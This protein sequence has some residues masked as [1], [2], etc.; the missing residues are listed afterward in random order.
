MHAGQ[1]RAALSPCR[2]HLIDCTTQ[3]CFTATGEVWLLMTESLENLRAGTLAG[4]VRLTLSCGLTEFPSEIYALAE[5]LETLDLSGNKLSSL[6]DDLHRLK[7][8]RVLFCSDNLFTELPAVLGQF[9]RLSMIGFKANRISHVP[10]TSL[11]HSLRWLILTDNQIAEL[12]DEIGDCPDLQ[13]LMLAGNRLEALPRTLS[14]C[15]KLALLRIAA[16]R[17]EEFPAWLL[18]MPELAWLAFAGNP[19]CR[20]REQAALGES[21]IPALPWPSLEIGEQLG[22]GASGVI[23]RARMPLVDE[24]NASDASGATDAAGAS[25]AADA[26]DASEAAKAS[27]AVDAPEA[28]KAS[29]AADAA[30]ARIVTDT[31]QKTASIEIAVKLFKGAITSDG[32]PES[33]MAACFSAPRHAHLI[34]ILGRVTGHPEQSQ[35]MVM[36]LMPPG[37]IN[38]AGPPSLDSCTRDVYPEH[39]RF[40]V[41]AMLQIATAMAGAGRHLAGHGIL[42]GDL[43]G[44]NILHDLEGHALLGDFGAASLYDKDGPYAASLQR[45]E[46]RAFGYLLEEMLARVAVPLALGESRKRLEAL[47]KACLS[48]VLRERPSFAEIEKILAQKKPATQEAP[49][50]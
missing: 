41:D 38:M 32:L 46:V 14:N 9:E 21:S 35:G 44:H 45:L 27:D 36:P 5:T 42:H 11:P 20:A 25:E 31:G 28:A 23:Y 17:L 13:K 12:P 1:V 33:E 34:P 2:V 50:V 26:S 7:K 47:L 24:A 8:L 10:A 19:F 22:Q 43:Y 16:N 30:D 15:R 3:P 49:P 48:P 4:A 37:L 29:D 40:S 39:V 18:A 6:P